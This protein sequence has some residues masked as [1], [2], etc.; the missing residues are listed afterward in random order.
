M[1]WSGKERSDGGVSTK[2]LGFAD[3]NTPDDGR[4]PGV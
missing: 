3:L 1:I 2:A 4:F